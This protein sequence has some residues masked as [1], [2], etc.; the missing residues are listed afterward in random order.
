M[1]GR[2]TKGIAVNATRGS[3]LVE[4]LG[5]IVGGIVLGGLGVLLALAGFIP[6]KMS[7]LAVILVVRG[8][9]GL[10]AAPFAP[11]SAQVIDAHRR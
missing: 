9:F 5:F 7:I 11:K 6:I 4:A 10:I 2:P 8:L 3:K 1:G